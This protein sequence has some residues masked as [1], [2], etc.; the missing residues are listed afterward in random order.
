[1]I[2]LLITEL[3]I[4][5]LRK[6]EKLLRSLFLCAALSAATELMRSLTCMVLRFK[7]VLF[8]LPGFVLLFNLYFDKVDVSLISHLWNNDSSPDNVMDPCQKAC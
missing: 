6:S 2:G 4:T 7:L 1:M 8:K 5:G 3:L